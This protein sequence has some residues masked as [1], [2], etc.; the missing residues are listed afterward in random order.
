MGSATLLD[1][2]R[3]AAP[4]SQH[5]CREAGCASLMEIFGGFMPARSQRK[6]RAPLT[7]GDAS[8]R[9]R[10]TPL[11]S[12]G[13]ATESRSSVLVESLAMGRLSRGAT[14]DQ[15][16]HERGNPMAGYPAQGQTPHVDNMPCKGRAR[17]GGG[18]GVHWSAALYHETPTEGGA[19]QITYRSVRGTRRATR[20]LAA[21]F[22][23]SKM[24]ARTRAASSAAAF[25]LD[26][27]DRR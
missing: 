27:G 23:T 20:L 21:S 8:S 10:C 6:S 13:A 25:S 5:A 18:G 16:C 1:C 26:G 3:G 19:I 15:R 7:D 24:R 11:L 14:G 9:S 2:R 12:S 17:A 22:T 4:R